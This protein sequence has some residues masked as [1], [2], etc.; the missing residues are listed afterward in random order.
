LYTNTHL[1]LLEVNIY[2]HFVIEQ[3]DKEYSP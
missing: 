3:S 2:F 1:V